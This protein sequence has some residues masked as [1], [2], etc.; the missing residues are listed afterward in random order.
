VYQFNLKDRAIY[1]GKYGPS[2]TDEIKAEVEKV[3]NDII[4]DKGDLLILF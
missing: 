1:L 3:K 4:N 2:V